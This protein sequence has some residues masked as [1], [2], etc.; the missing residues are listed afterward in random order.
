MWLDI[1]EFRT[2]TDYLE[3]EVIK[4]FVE[5]TIYVLVNYMKPIAHRMEVGDKRS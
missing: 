3:Q 4:W 5:F 2:R 1:K